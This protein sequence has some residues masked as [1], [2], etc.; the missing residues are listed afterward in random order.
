VPRDPFQGGCRGLKEP[1]GWGGVRHVPPQTETEAVVGEVRSV[2]LFNL[3]PFPGWQPW[4]VEKR[5]PRFSELRETGPM[6]DEFVAV[7]HGCLAAIT[8]WFRRSGPSL[9]TTAP[10]SHTETFNLYRP[11]V[12]RGLSHAFPLHFL[13]LGEGCG[14]CPSLGF[15]DTGPHAQAGTLI[16]PAY[17]GTCFRPPV[18]PNKPFGW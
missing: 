17:V 4:L 16:S 6:K 7:T 5:G 9:C 11:L 12:S 1:R 10:N 13:L 8:L 3:S 15:L 14:R 2:D 18:R